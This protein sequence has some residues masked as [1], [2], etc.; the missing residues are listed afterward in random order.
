MLSIREASS[1]SLALGSPLMLDSL[2]QEAMRNLS[3]H[4]L[5]HIWET[6]LRQHPIDQALT[7]LR[8]ANPDLRWDELETLS[9]GQRDARLMKVWERTFGPELASYA[10]CPQCREQL[11]FTLNT[12]Q[13]YAD[14]PVWVAGATYQWM[15][16]RYVVEFRLPNS[17]D[18]AA[19]VGCAQLEHA[20]QTLVNRCIVAALQRG[21][22]IAPSALPD[23]IIGDIAA[24]MTKYDPLAEVMLDLTCP[25]CETGWQA[26]FDISAFLW[27]ELAVTAKRLLR[28]IH[29]L[30]R[31]YGWREADILALSATRRQCY[32]ELVS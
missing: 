5:I 4:D 27:S 6:S 23:P 1:L 32:L 18:L 10:E 11:E 30:A 24:R 21:E 8:A 16:D 7:M 9:I 25:A 2:R 12:T 15:D 14:L 22:P 17:R 29:T 31:A 28:E 26:L 13:L 19:L 20:R 3:E